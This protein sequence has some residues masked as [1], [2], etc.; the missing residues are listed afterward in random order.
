MKDY[1]LGYSDVGYK[2]SFS[3]G[4][5]NAALPITMLNNKMLTARAYSSTTN[6]V[7]DITVEDDDAV[8]LEAIGICKHN[9]TGGT[10]Q[11]VCYS[12]ALGGTIEYDS[13]SL[14]VGTPYEKLFTKTIVHATTS[15]LSFKYWRITLT[16]AGNTDGFIKVGRIFL[17]KRFSNERNMGYGLTMITQDKS[18]KIVSSDSGVETYIKNPVLRGTVFEMKLDNYTSGD[19]FSKLNIENGLTESLLFEL[20][21]DNIRGGLRSFIGRSSSLNPLQYPH[22]S[23][24]EYSF[25][26]IEII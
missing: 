21:P 24:N 19:E 17:G 16:D 18:S 25:S 20:D 4:T 8:D 22:F 23:I 5:W 26:L 10:Y 6:A 15:A 7:I 11:I 13:G 14:P 3:G 12:N 1:I 2:S 9:M